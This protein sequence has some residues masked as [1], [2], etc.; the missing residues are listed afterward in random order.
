MGSFDVQGLQACVGISPRG[1]KRYLRR[2]DK[3]VPRRHCPAIA[4]LVPLP[5]TCLN[6]NSVPVAATIRDD[7]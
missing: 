2:S 6:S 5:T 4:H 7:F 3:S 1:G